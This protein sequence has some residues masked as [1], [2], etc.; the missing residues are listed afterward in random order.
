MKDLKADPEVLAFLSPDRVQ[1]CPSQ[2]PVSE[3]PIKAWC[4]AMGDRNPVYLDPEAARRYGH[5]DVFAPPVMMHAFTLPG[6]LDPNEDHLLSQ[7]RRKLAEYGLNSVVAGNYE[8]EFITP[9]RLGDRLTREVRFE[10]I[11]DEK[12][13]AVGTGHFVLMAERIVNQDGKLI[14]LQRMRSLFFRPGAP[15]DRERSPKRTDPA[16]EAPQADPVELPPLAIPLTTT[17]II[18]AAVATNDFEPMHHDRDV[19]QGQGMKD[20]FMN[21]L[22]SCGLAIRYVTDWAGPE[23]TILG[24]SSRF[25]ASNFPGDTMVFTGVADGPFRKGSENKIHVR[26]TNSFGTHIESTITVV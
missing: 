16:I 10:S 21:I 14:G 23:A 9:I 19:A 18:A 5:R 2:A 3:W 17:L 20:I 15:P 11:S 8:Q 24:H 12:S 4:R 6:L 7:L 13:T 1:I 26:G 22:S 25:M